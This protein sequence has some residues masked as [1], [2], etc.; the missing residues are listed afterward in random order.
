MWNHVEPCSSSGNFDMGPQVEVILVYYMPSSGPFW[1]WEG[2]GR[3]GGGGQGMLK[4]R[5][6][7]SNYEIWDVTC[8]VFT[9]E[10]LDC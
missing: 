9:P 3:G 8:S 7:C 6:A 5:I 2:S 1:E 10:K 4:L